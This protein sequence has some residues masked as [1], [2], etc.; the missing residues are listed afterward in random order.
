MT[1]STLTHGLADLRTA[2]IEI[3][4]GGS[5]P[6]DYD[7]LAANEK[8]TVDRIVKSGIRQFYS[9]PIIGGRSHDWSF[10]YINTTLTTNAPY[11]TGT[12]T[13]AS[14]V[15][16]LSGGTFPSWAAS[17]M[18]AISGN[19]YSV[20]SRDSDTQITLDDTSVTEVS[21]TE[22]SL[23][24]DDYTLPDDFSRIIGDATFQQSA[25]AWEP[26]RITSEAR[27][28]ALRQNDF[29]QN[30]AMDEPLRA[31]I[32]PVVN[33]PTVG[34]RMQ[35]QFWPRITSAK[36]IGYRYRVRDDAPTT[37]NKYIYGASDHSETITASCQAMAE[38]HQDRERGPF[39][40]HF[41]QMLASS[42]ERDRV[43]N[44]GTFLG[45]NGDASDGAEMFGGQRWLDSPGV[46]YKGQGS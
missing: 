32:V 37:T 10:L 14:G 8:A 36:I 43:A 9:P 24:Q 3:V 22:Y 7:N 11:A 19:D 41:M 18:L 5:D 30:F 12:V 17:G 4:Y 6:T 23:H 28:R 45:Y 1:E 21:A 20:D 13:I 15:V 27:I 2:I 26:C 44:S 31:A 16:T 40:A 39:H 25:N 33:D 38:L 29:Q 42:V 35:I 34:T 46:T